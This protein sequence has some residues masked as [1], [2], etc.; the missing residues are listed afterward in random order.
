MCDFSFWRAPEERFA[1]PIE[2]EKQSPTSLEP[3]SSSLAS[4]LLPPASCLLVSRE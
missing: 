2:W 3:P 1:P 4:C